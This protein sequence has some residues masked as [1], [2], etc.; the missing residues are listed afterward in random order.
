MRKNLA[1]TNTDGDST[2]FYGSN[3]K[4]WDLHVLSRPNF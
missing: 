4:K 1:E 2:D 3:K